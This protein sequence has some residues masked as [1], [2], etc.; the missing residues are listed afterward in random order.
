MIETRRLKNVVIFIQTILS[1]VLSR[2]VI[3]IYNDI[4][5]KY[6]NV[7]E[8]FLKGRKVNISLIFILL[9]DFKMCKTIRLNATHHFIM[10]IPNKTDLQQI[11]SN[12]SSDIDFKDFIKL[13]KD[14]TKEPYSFLVNDTTLPSDNPLRIR[15]NLVRK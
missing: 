2:K 14:Y 10:K 13:Y 6:G 15:K 7:T 8:L 9:S 1:F 4:A 5:R 12:N 11:G 3:N